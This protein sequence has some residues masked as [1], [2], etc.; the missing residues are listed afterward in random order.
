MK[1]PPTKPLRRLVLELIAIMSI[2]SL[3]SSKSGAHWWETHERMAELVCNTYVNDGKGQY[4]NFLQSIASDKG[5]TYID[6]LKQGVLDTDLRVGGIYAVD[7][8]CN[9]RPPKRIDCSGG[10]DCCPPEKIVFNDI[11]EVIVG[12]HGYNP[13]TRKSGS[14][15]PAM[16][17]RVDKDWPGWENSWNKKDGG[18]GDKLLTV[19]N[20][21][22][23]SQKKTTLKNL[24]KK[25]TAADLATFFYNRA[26]KEWENNHP[27][28]A[29]Y[30]LGIALHAVQDVTNPSHSTLGDDQGFEQYVN[31]TY[32][33]TIETNP[34]AISGRY[35][36]KR[37]ADWV[38]MGATESYNWDL[39]NHPAFP[40]TASKSV[41]LGVG[42]GAGFLWSFFNDADIALPPPNKCDYSI[43]PT[44][45]TVP[46]QGAS[47]S[48]NVN[49]TAG[50]NCSWTAS[51]NSGS[52]DWIGISSG[53]SG[54]GNG[55][56]NYSVL[57]NTGL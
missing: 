42:S 9:T 30:N 12:D 40:T 46:P 57:A 38:K 36:K 6:L 21:K 48:V 4:C 55:T 11:P 35:L 26:L 19:L 50:V 3:Y 45:V 8:H 28:D 10:E 15:S 29:F 54:K 25:A 23:S 52:W 34:P 32:L 24:M 5:R 47:G 41:A 2:I 37:P 43:S 31:D 14:S 39:N 18:P 20:G 1:L 13:K 56:A 44:S 27:G 22:T 53:T 51:T 33:T 17:D 7:K 49:V 16:M